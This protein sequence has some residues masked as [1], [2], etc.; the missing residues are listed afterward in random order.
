MS[1]KAE[2]RGKLRGNLECGSAQPSLLFIYLLLFIKCEYKASQASLWPY[3]LPGVGKISLDLCES[4]KI[5]LPNVYISDF[6][7][8]RHKS[9]VIEA[10]G[11]KGVVSIAGECSSMYCVQI[12][13]WCINLIN[14]IDDVL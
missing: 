7:K 2:F 10:N 11:D 3:P 9:L 6:A 14:F 12:L 4:C 5:N 13:P 8:L 1:S